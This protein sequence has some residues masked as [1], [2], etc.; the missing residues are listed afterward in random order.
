[1]IGHLDIWVPLGV[2][3]TQQLKWRRLTGAM[4]LQEVW[5]G[6]SISLRDIPLLDEL[7]S[8][9]C[10]KQKHHRGG[11]G[12]MNKY[13]TRTVTTRRGKRRLYLTIRYILQLPLI[14]F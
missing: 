5:Y 13:P 3:P 4:L 9:V 11:L 2:M 14:C 6:T 7:K 1:M 10:E 12:A 8:D